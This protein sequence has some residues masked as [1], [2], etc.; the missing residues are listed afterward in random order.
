M[1]KWIIPKTGVMMAA[2][3]FADMAAGKVAVGDQSIASILLPTHYNSPALSPLSTGMLTS[4]TLQ[5]A[6]AAFLASISTLAPLHPTNQILYLT[7]DDA[8]FQS[9]S[10]YYDGIDALI[11]LLPSHI[12]VKYSDVATYLKAVQ[13]ASSEEANVQHGYKGSLSN[14][15]SSSGHSWSGVYSTRMGLK[16]KIR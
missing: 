14:Y 16:R 6:L 15:H 9:P 7:G 4:A 12:T 8:A 10:I 5:T 13:N 11:P 2:P 1:F 3:E